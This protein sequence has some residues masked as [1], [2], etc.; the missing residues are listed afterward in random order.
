MPRVNLTE[1]EAELIRKQREH[2]REYAT[3]WNAAIDAI[4]N[5]YGDLEDQHP[6]HW[7]SLKVTLTELY[8][9]IPKE[10]K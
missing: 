9:V 5:V 6:I 10:K 4:A 2:A 1:A 3:A 8:R 7:S